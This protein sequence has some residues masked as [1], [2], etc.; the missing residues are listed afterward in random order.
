MLPIAKSTELLFLNKTL[1]DDFSRDTGVKQEALS[2][3]ESLF[4]A[5]SAYYDWSAGQAM[6]QIN[7]FYHYFLAAMASLG[8][9][10]IVDG[11]INAHDAAFEAAFVPMAEAAV[12]GGLCVGD[13]YAS[14]RW[15]TAEVISNIGSSAGILYLRDYVTYPDNT[16]RDIETAVAAYPVFDG[17]APTVVQRGGGLFAVKS[18]DDRCNEAAAVFAKWV[19]MGQPNLDFVTE[20]G[21]LPVTGDAFDL[22][23]NSLETVENPKYRLLYESV[24]AVYDRYDFRALPL[25]EGAGAA[26][27]DFEKTVKA[28]LSAAHEAYISRTQAGEDGQ[29]V[30]AQL[31]ESA[32]ADVRNA[33]SGK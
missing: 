10:F 24:G 4:A 26:Q 1:F 23:F 30:L 5:C 6:F 20:A 22:L 21:Y 28:A 14:D 13:G 9:E 31:V 18:E 8:S 12:Y 2:D 3:F 29:A 15:K 27:S 17:A 11:A 25:Y 19:T 33:V 32:L 7:D 16:T